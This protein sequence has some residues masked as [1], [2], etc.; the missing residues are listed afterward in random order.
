MVNKIFSI[1]EGVKKATNITKQVSTKSIDSIVEEVN[2]GNINP[3]EAYVMLDYIQKVAAEALNTIKP[4]TLD[5]IMSVGENRAFGVELQPVKRNNYV[6]SEDTE[7]SRIE[8]QMSIYK[9]ALKARE[10]FIK[11][12]VEIALESGVKTPVN[13]NTT[14]FLRPKNIS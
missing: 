4:N 3:V 6:Y 1:L 8:K 7:W 12:N 5:Y 10:E 2:V 11:N 9:D 13:F 14:V